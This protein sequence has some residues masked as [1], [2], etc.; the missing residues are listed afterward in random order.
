MRKPTEKQE[1]FCKEYIIDFNGTRAYID[2]Y[3][4]P[5]KKVK[6]SVARTQAS[7]LLAKAN[8]NTRIEELKKER[9][10]RLEV[11]ADWVL[12]QA[13]ELLEIAKGEKPHIQSVFK[14]GR[15]VSINTVSDEEKV[16][17]T[18]EIEAH[19]NFDKLYTHKWTNLILDCGQYVR[20]KENVIG[21]Y[22]V[23]V[24]QKGQWMKQEVCKTNIKEANNILNTIGKHTNVK[25][26]A[27]EVEN[28]TQTIIA[29]GMPKAQ[30]D[31]KTQK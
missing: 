5:T 3:S 22:V 19:E 10:E 13:Q 31:E 11:N 16:R 20:I 21:D 17:I 30:E 9:N 7:K 24:M 2:A 14:E 18:Q 4:T 28:N 23:E 12:K 27:Q 8:I 29:V 26:F 1:I 6:N 15:Y 25:A